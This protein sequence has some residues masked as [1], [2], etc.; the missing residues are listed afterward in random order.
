LEN[1]SESG[2]DCGAGVERAICDMVFLILSIKFIVQPNPAEASRNKL[3]CVG[4]LL[5]LA[6]RLPPSEDA[7]SHENTKAG[8]TL[9]ARQMGTLQQE[10]PRI[11]EDAIPQQRAPSPGSDIIKG[12]PAD[13]RELVCLTDKSRRRPLRLT[14][15]LPPTRAFRQHGTRIVVRP[16]TLQITVPSAPEQDNFPASSQQISVPSPPKQNTTQQ[17][18]TISVTIH[19]SIKERLQH[20][21]LTSTLNLQADEDAAFSQEQ[22]DK[23]IRLSQLLNQNSTTLLRKLESQNIVAVLVKIG[24]PSSTDKSD[25]ICI[26]GLQKEEDIL[27]FHA[28]VSK[29]LYRK[30]YEPLGLCYDRRLV[31][32]AAADEE[33]SD[34]VIE[35]EFTLCG[36]LVQATRGG[37]LKWMSTIGGLIEIDGQMYALTTLHHAH[38]AKSNMRSDSQGDE[39]ENA[40]ESLDTLINDND[41]DEEVQQALFVD[42]WKQS[43]AD[44]G[45]VSQLYQLPPRSAKAKPSSGIVL[46]K[47]VAQGS[48]WSLLSV[49]RALWRPNVVSIQQITGNGQSSAAGKASNPTNPVCITRKY[50][51]SEGKSLHPTKKAVQVIA[52][53]SGT[54]SGV[55]SPNPSFLKLSC[56]DFSLVWTVWLPQGVGKILKAHSVKYMF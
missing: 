45:F 47:T 17:H 22:W 25:Y 9:P 3:G 31:S 19:R 21:N 14:L 27:L 24:A 37:S 32:K 28:R 26:K 49:D 41:F 53:V 48:D 44:V 35:G 29:K 55:L 56:A 7:A 1:S 11:E 36:T 30:E 13:P 12:V 5:F 2:S 42:R 43:R 40:S 20:F 50:L 38:E 51:I 4:A 18:H 52:G 33:Y 46:G 34:N 15:R 10:R 39:S 6:I 23:V 54:L 8:G 16:A